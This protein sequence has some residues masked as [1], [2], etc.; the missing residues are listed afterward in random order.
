MSQQTNFRMLT[1]AHLRRS[2]RQ[3]SLLV[4]IA[5]LSG[6]AALT[7][8]SC[9]DDTNPGAG[10][11]G[12]AATGGA[13]GGASPAGGAGRG[14]EVASGG[15]IAPGE[16]GGEGGQHTGRAGGGA[17]GADGAALQATVKVV[18]L[19]AAGHDRFYK[20][21]F[22]KDGAFFAVGQVAPGTESTT[23]QA[24]VLARF[25]ANGA[26]A[27]GFGDNGFV[28][29]N[30]AVGGSGELAR[31]LAVQSTG[32]VVIAGAMEH[33]GA[34]DARD[35]DVFVARFDGTTGALDPTFGG[36]GVVT[37]DW[38]TGTVVGSA[39]LADAHWGLSVDAADRIFVSGSRVNAAGTNTELVTARLTADGVLD[40]T[41]GTGGLGAAGLAGQ[42]ISARTNSVLADGSVI[43]AGYTN[44]NGV[45]SPVLYKLDAQGVLDPS[46]ANGGIFNRVLWPVSTECYGAVLQS[47]GSLV[48]AGYGK[49]VSSDSTDWVSFRVTSA[50]AVDTTYG[51]SG[52]GM[53][54]IDVAGFND[55]ARS[56]MV[57]PDDRVVLSGGARPVADNVDGMIVVLGKDGMPDTTFAPLGR[58]SIDLGG[59][60]D[61]VWGGALAPDGKT[62]VFAG[63]KGAGAAS[64]GAGGAGGAGGGSGADDDAALVFLPL[65]PSQ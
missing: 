46:F 29:K 28:I 21:A 25:T 33:V 48:T 22:A 20:V 41:F 61:F 10:S 18:P 39:F 55:N 36:G 37:L 7:N 47:S 60:N 42:N 53:V 52:D 11:G 13:A 62:L 17:G 24:T 49:R 44:A 51:P 4:G 19:S 15:K 30:F 43:G 34:T 32:K 6:G 56:V 40:A 63:I 1:K 57:L 12:P 26:N 9:S 5:A 31:G 27:P 58:V 2:L 50:G 16:Q 54:G 64:T 65:G 45:T 14:G 59:A 23:D 35:R 3:G 38:S 8:V